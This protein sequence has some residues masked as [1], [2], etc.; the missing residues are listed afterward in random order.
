[1][2]DFA[3][4]LEVNLAFCHCHGLAGGPSLVI[5]SHSWENW[6]NNTRFCHAHRHIYPGSNI[7]SLMMG[8]VPGFLF[9]ANFGQMVKN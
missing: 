1:M 4:H 7:S 2:A 9:L 3:A 6:E 8:F 5:R